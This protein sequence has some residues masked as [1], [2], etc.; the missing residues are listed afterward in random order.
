MSTS[1]VGATSFRTK[2][3]GSKLNSPKRF[4]Y[5]LR[6]IIIDARPEVLLVLSEE[7]LVQQ[8]VNGNQAA[9]T[10]L[11]NQNFD[12]IHR[13]IY[14]KVRD[15]AEAED[16]TQDV[17]IRALESINTYKWR[18]LPFAAWLFKIAH[19]RVIDHVRKQSKE[20]RAPLE[21]AYTRSVEDPIQMTERDYEVYQLKVA[22]EQLPEAQRDVATLRFIGQLSIAEVART[23]GKSEG[24]VK[25]LQFNATASLRK[26]LYGKL[27]G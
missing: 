10:Q 8:A 15:R 2:V 18:D 12:R 16:L 17:F 9:F 26:A 7:Y 14:I 4:P 19:N 25:A 1:F 3:L 11:Y 22:L 5:I 24:T 6:S 13:Y 27:D 23:L 21:E 20:K